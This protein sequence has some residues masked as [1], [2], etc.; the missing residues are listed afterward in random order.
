MRDRLA[1][2]DVGTKRIGVAVSDALGL[3][4]QPLCVVERRGTNADIDCILE[5]LADYGITRIVAGLPLEMDGAEGKQAAF[6]RRFCDALR[7]RSGLEVVYQDERLTSAEGERLLIESGMRRARR[8]GVID[9]T[10]A[11]LIL[12]CFLDAAQTATTE[13]EQ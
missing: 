1:A 2:L 6:V 13:P 5:A 11:A 4:A 7:E 3:T 10:A 9:K 12:Q 8:R